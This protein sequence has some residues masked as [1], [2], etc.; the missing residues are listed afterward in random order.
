MGV[1]VKFMKKIELCFPN[2]FKNHSDHVVLQE[3]CARTKHKHTRILAMLPP[4]CEVKFPTSGVGSG[5]ASSDV[6]HRQL[7]RSKLYDV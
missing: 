4:M 3:E 1:P 5:P 7:W 2:T 6:K